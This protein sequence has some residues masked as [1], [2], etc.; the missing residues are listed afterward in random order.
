MII[1]DVNGVVKIDGYNKWKDSIE[2]INSW[3]DVYSIYENGQLV[4]NSKV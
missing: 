2:N 1:I 4:I 3:V